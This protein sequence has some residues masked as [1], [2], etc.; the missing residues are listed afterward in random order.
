MTMKAIKNIEQMQAWSLRQKM[1][2]KKIGF[3]PTMG[4]LH[5]GHL[6]LIRQAKK[7]S[8]VVVVSIYVNPTQF[9]PGEDLE[10]YPRDFDRDSE[11]CRKEGVNVIFYPSDK[12]MYS[13]NHR[14][15]VVSEEISV[16]LCGRSRPTHF[17]GVTTIV[18]KLFNIVMPDSAVFGQKDFQQS[19]IIRKMVEDLNFNVKIVVSPIVR[20]AD[21]LA[22]SSRNK[23]LSET[24]RREAVML[25][26]SLKLAE[27]EY[28]AGNRNSAAII[29][30]MRDFLSSAST[31]KIDY[32]EMA[33]A[34]TLEKPDLGRRDTV[35]ALAAFCGQTRLIDNI[36]FE[37]QQ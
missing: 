33:D 35:L 19:V 17:R 30:K 1:A 24:Q 9:A 23:Y 7:Q 8:D 37:K 12:A 25:Y 21:G 32:I 20:E 15:Y 36:I 6:S 10:K 18:S 2:G 3:V 28:T 27:R 14:T 26:Q 34:E 16:I 29:A 5:E 4:F 22:M 11:L 13:P 31:I